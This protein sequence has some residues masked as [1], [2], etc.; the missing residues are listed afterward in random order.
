MRVL[1][2]AREV[3]PLGPQQDPPARAD[4]GDRSTPSSSTGHP[5]FPKSESH[6]YPL[7]TNRVLC[8]SDRAR[9][10]VVGVAIAGA[11]TGTALVATCAPAPP[12]MTEKA[13]QQSQAL[14]VKKETRSP[15]QQ[16]F[17]SRLFQALTHHR[18]A[19]ES[20]RKLQLR[21]GVKIEED[22]TTIVDIKAEVTDGVLAQIKELGGIIINQV[23]KY[24]HIRAKMPLASLETLAMLP[25]VKSICAAAEARTRGRPRS[26]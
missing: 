16:K 15:A 20:S 13:K 17:C 6:S 11:L 12:Q 14:K 3:S 25:E 5:G 9:W 1:L 24:Q 18:G 21:S 8:R 26:P 23:P 19:G 7:I 10:C 22:G 2:R 4:F